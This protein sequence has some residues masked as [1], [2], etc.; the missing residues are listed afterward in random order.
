MIVTYLDKNNNIQTVKDVTDIKFYK[1]NLSN[2]VEHRATIF[3]NKIHIG[4]VQYVTKVI[5]AD[6]II[7]ITDRGEKK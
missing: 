6:K 7:E 1:L 3:Y 5:E 2:R 4:R